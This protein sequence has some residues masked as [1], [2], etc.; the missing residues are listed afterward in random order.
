MEKSLLARHSNDTNRT[1]P[2]TEAQ[3][4]ARGVRFICSLH[5]RMRG[6]GFFAVLIICSPACPVSRLEWPFLNVSTLQHVVGACALAGKPL[7]DFRSVA[8]P[9]IPQ[10]TIR[11]AWAR[12]RAA[13]RIKPAL[14]LGACRIR[15]RSSRSQRACACDTA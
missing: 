3:K 10:G 11:A 8:P 12:A 4:R 6:T 2:V 5:Y 13:S 9:K 15:R 1:V 7:L 14:D